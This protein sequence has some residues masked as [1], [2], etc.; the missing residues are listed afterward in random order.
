MREAL[1]TDAMS[2]LVA[3]LANAPDALVENTSNGLPRSVEQ[4]RRNGTSDWSLDG[5]WRDEPN[6]LTPDGG[7]LVGLNASTLA[8]ITYAWQKVYGDAS[9]EDIKAGVYERHHASDLVKHLAVVVPATDEVEDTAERVARYLPANY[10]V[11]G[12]ETYRKRSEVL[13]RGTDVAGWTAEGYVIPRLASGLL[14]AE[15][16]SLSRQ[17]VTA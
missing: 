3:T 14:S 15:V 4:A 7:T 9:W 2:F 8:A 6:T 12:T 13:V 17:A 11:V 16:Y 1:C 5:G 10:E